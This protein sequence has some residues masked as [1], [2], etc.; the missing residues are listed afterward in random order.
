VARFVALLASG[1]AFGAIIAVVALGFLILYKATGV[2]NFAHGDLMTLGAYIAVWAIADLKLPIV[3]GYVVALVLMAVVGLVLER[4]AY[5]PLRNKPPNVVLVATLGASLVIEAVI[6]LWQG[7]NP[8]ELAS[9]VGYGVVHIAGA[10]I[11]DQRILVVIVAGIA[12]AACM[13]VFQRTQFGR[14][15]RAL[16]VDQETAMLYGVRVRRVS[17]LAFMISAVF[18]GLGGILITPLTSV[19]IDFGFNT[20]LTAFAAAIIGGFGSLGGTAAAALAIGLLQQL[21]GGYILTNYSDLLPFLAIL[22]A[23]VIRPKGVLGTIR[24]VRV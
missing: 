7:S 16:A 23:V 6:A 12:I 2:V 24:N 14:Q 1:I 9:P 3:A 18:A 15:V 20:L 10:A 8:E 17:A 22:V 13:Y 4:V 19:T 21:V 11:A 5:V